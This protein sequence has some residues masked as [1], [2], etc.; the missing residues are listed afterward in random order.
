MFHVF[1]IGPSITTE[2]RISQRSP[3]YG[4]PVHAETA[5]GY[6]PCRSCLNVFREGQERRL[7]FTYNPFDGLD[8]YPLPGPVFIHETECSA[9]DE[10]AMFPPALRKLP[11]TLE[12]YGADRWLLARERPSEPE[13]EAAIESLFK[14]AEV[15]YIHVR[16]TEAGCYI[17]RVER[18]I[19]GG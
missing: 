18:A 5:A 14:D 13:I 12:G 10:G 9:Y 3:Q 17:A 19:S 4:H 16:N 2:V 11:L 6:G 8:A 15:R 7:L 1:P